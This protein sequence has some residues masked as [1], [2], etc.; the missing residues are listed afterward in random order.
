[1]GTTFNSIWLLKIDSSGHKVNLWA[2]KKSETHVSC[3]FCLQDIKY[4]KQ[5]WRALERHSETTK[6]RQKISDSI[7]KR[8]FRL[9]IVKETENSSS[10]VGIDN[11]YRDSDTIKKELIWAMHIIMKNETFNSADKDAQVLKTIAPDV[12]Q[13]FSLGRTKMSYLLNEALAP[14]FQSLLVDDIVGYF[15]ISYDETTNSENKKELQI[16]IKYWSKQFQK[17]QNAHLQ[18]FFITYAHST[19]LVKYIKKST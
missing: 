7:D 1:M 10:I 18:T 12:F 19:D 8:Q 11:V 16:L 2:K 17:V 3:F 15:S 14:H 13:C 4:S 9:G 5:G 6:H